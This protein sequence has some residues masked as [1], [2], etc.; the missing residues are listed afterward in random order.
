M[1]ASLMATSSGEACDVQT[2]LGLRL[3][4]LAERM[5]ERPA[6]THEG[7]TRSYRELEERTNRLA[8]A[9]AGLGVGQDS[10]VTIGLPNGIEFIE[11]TLAAYKLGATPL[12]ISWRLPVMERDAIIE[13]ASPALLVG[14][15]ATDRSDCPTVPAGFEPDPGLSCEPLSG[16]AGSWWKALTSGGSTGRPKLIVSTTPAIFETIASLGVQLQMRPDGAQLVAGPFYHNAP[17]LTGIVGLLSG[18]HQ[19]VLTRFDAETCLAQIEQHRIDWI[20]LVPTMM[21][22]IMRLPEDVRSRYDL[23][24]LRIVFHGAAPCPAWLKEAWIEWLGPDRIW[25][26]YAGTE[27]LA[28]TVI[29]GEEWLA[30]KGSVGKVAAGQIRVLGPDGQDLPPGQVGA[31]WMRRGEDAPPDYRYIGAMPTAREGGWESLGDLG[32]FDPDGYLYLTD[33][34]ADMILVG[35]ANVYPAEIEAALEQ[36]PRVLSSCVIGLP[37]EDLGNVLHAIIQ[38][39]GGITDDELLAHLRTRLVTYKLPRSFEY[40]T[41]PLRGDDGKMRRSALRTARLQCVS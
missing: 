38:A 30:H 5:P 32:Y 41:D 25:E 6:V 18:N 1:R 22:R 28:G 12:P 7:V 9:Y 27:G 10:F 4:Y 40:V 20:Y 26:L 19:V 17:F 36:H 31:I 8:R 21:H 39:D 35:G 37:D 29:S 2:P 13:L 15:D 11:A 34:E 3:T 24:S 16:K 23:S 33:R 14:V